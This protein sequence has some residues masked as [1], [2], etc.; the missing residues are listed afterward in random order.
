MQQQK[1]G[2]EDG[3][4]DKKYFTIIPNYVLNHS[5]MWDREV[6]IQMKRIA[7]EHGICWTSQ[8]TLAEQCGMSINRLKKSIQYLLDHKWIKD[9]GTKRVGT[10]GGSQEVNQYKIIDLWQKNIEFYKKEGVSTDDTPA[11]KRTQRGITGAVKGVS[12]SDDK[13]EQGIKKN[14]IIFT[15]PSAA[16]KEINDLIELFKSVNPS[17]KTLY[18]MTPQRKAIERMIKEHGVEKIRKSILLLRQTNPSEFAPTIT[19]PYQ[20][21]MKLGQLIA[22]FQKQRSKKTKTKIPT[23]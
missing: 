2:I 21:E 13:E 19:T 11:Q 1:L 20:L 5:T 12:P 16:G 3:S 23:L 18:A 7:G 4:N 9:Y 22:F 6:Y 8:K 17:Y 14:P 15:A 10:S